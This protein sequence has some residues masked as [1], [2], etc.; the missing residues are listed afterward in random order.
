[1]NNVYMMRFILYHMQ[2]TLLKCTQVEVFVGRW[3]AVRIFKG[4]WGPPGY[5]GFRLWKMS[6]SA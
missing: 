4:E 6:L 5:L 1:M 2:S 3:L